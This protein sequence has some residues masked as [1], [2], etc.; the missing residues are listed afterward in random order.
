MANRS[1]FPQQIDEFIENTE[2][3]A[4][5]RPLLLRYQ[6]LKLKAFRLPA[7]DDELAY[8]TQQL[9]TKLMTSEDYN[10]MKNA[11]TNTQSFFRDSVDG[12]IQTKQ[13]EFQTEIDKFT[14]KGE[15]NPNTRYFTRNTVTFNGETYL[16]QKESQGI[17]PNPDVN[18]VT[19]AKVAKKGDK[20]DKG[21]PGLGLR[22]VGTWSQAIPYT[23]ND[24]VQFGGNVYACLKDVIGIPP[25][26]D[27]DTEYW[28]FAVARGETIRVES[29]KNTV[30]VSN[31]VA[32]VS[33]GIPSFN[34]LT[35]MLTVIKNTATLAE[36]TN[37]QIS[38][39]G[40]L[41]SS[42]EGTWN[43]TEY[44]ITF[45]FVVTKNM[46]AS[47]PFLNELHLQFVEEEVEYS[48]TQTANA[49]LV[50]DETRYVND[51]N[52]TVNY[53][54]N[55]IVSFNGSSYMAIKDTIGN[56]PP[57]LP[58]TANEFWGLSGRKGA[59]GTGTLVRHREFFTS[60]EGQKVFTLSNSYDQHVNMIDV[61]VGGVPQYSPDNFTESSSTTIT[62]STGV[63]AGIPVIATYFSQT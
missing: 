14:H 39:T 60:T 35:D 56:T 31:S 32:S 16:N 15:Y 5:D 11:I 28:G 45:H 58:L 8:L 10:H 19:W 2:I 33:I 42:L 50:A 63:P 12:Y 23:V 47:A 18:T 1:T 21:A 4:S 34:P 20:G 29:L 48:K 37:Y 55:N 44:P 46:L 49:Q 6:E 41:I 36:G 25:R 38:N 9:R 30:V 54:K 22:F 43:G 24:A 40:E 62:L 51:Y 17:A 27:I 52:A 3:A 7:E 57:L 13:V 59:D 53:K 61:I 26:V